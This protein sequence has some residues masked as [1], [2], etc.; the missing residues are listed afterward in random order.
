MFVQLSRAVV[1]SVFL[2]P[3]AFALDVD[4]LNAV[5]ELTVWYAVH[6]D[7]ID[8][9]IA[10]AMVDEALAPCAAIELRAFDISQ[11]K[12][13]YLESFGGW[14]DAIEGG[15]VSHRIESNDG[16]NAV[17]LVCYTFQNNAVLNRETFAFNPDMQITSLVAEEVADNCNEF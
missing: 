15:L 6:A 7:A 2:S 13:E 9:S 11:N 4:Q 5:D 10:S 14:R 12:T 3:A 16:S 8:P 17:V 1:A